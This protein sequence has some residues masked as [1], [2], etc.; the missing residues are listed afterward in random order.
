MKI[1][2]RDRKNHDLTKIKRMYKVRLDA[3]QQHL[4][5]AR[6]SLM[7]IPEEG[8]PQATVGDP[9]I[10]QWS[11]GF[12]YPGVVSTLATNGNTGQMTIAFDTN[13]LIVVDQ[14]SVVVKRSV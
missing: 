4:W 11:K 14:K 13:D 2:K 9:V 3:S 5:A 7:E 10:A 6:E 12:W 8:A 1:V